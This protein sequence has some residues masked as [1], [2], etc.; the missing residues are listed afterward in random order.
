MTADARDAARAGRCDVVANIGKLV[1]EL[2]A[3]YYGNVFATDPVIASCNGVVV[4]VEQPAPTAQA[5]SPTTA[6]TLSIG[7]TAAGV[8][9]FGIADSTDDR[10]AANV[11]GWP[12]LA[13]LIVGPT[14]G[15]IYAGNAWNTG[16]KLRLAS[17]GLAAATI[18][19]IWQADI[20]EP[21]IA[22]VI[23]AVPIGAFF[24]AGWYEAFT[25]GR[26]ARTYNR[27]H[28]VEVGL[29]PIVGR[30]SGIALLGRF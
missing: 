2:D 28:Q 19:A 24:T 7:T 29:A 21:A 4:A 27:A 17:L 14:T 13:L 22:G 23:L 16:L 6:L 10:T 11:L 9:L 12:G 20:S 30:D 3:H 1:R 26:S 25:A 18:V 5:K 15:H 8:V